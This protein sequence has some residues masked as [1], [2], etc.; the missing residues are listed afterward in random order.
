MIEIFTDAQGH[1]YTV[2]EGSDVVLVAAYGRG[3]PLEMT[4]A[5]AR[6]QWS[7]SHRRVHAVVDHERARR[8]LHGW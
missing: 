2:V 5:E 4:R 3:Q 6:E 1:T 7:A 8:N